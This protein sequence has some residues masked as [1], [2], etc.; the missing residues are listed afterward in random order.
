MKETTHLF[1]YSIGQAWQET[2]PGWNILEIVY[3]SVWYGCELIVQTMINAGC[4]CCLCHVSS[5]PFLD[6]NCGMVIFVDVT[7]FLRHVNY[8]DM[9]IIMTFLFGWIML[10]IVLWF[11]Y[12]YSNNSCLNSRSFVFEIS[13]INGN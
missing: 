6:Y 9:W 10:N 11:I 12:F 5:F 7:A 8:Y 3:L 1:L 13:R 4:E 2:L